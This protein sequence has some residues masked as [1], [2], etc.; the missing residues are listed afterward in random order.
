ML[1]YKVTNNINGKIYIGQTRKSIHSR[2]A[3]HKSRGH[4]LYAAI[5]KYGIENFTVKILCRCN[6]LEEMNHRETYYIKLFKSLAPKG[7][8][9]NSGG[10]KAFEVS[11]ET[12]RRLSE[13]H[14]GKKAPWNSYKRSA[15]TREKLSRIFTGRPGFW[16]GKKRPPEHFKTD[17]VLCLNNGVTYRSHRE[18]A[19]ALKVCFKKISLVVKGKRN[20]TGGYRFVRAVMARGKYA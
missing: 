2:W 14:K 11:D 16:T 7:Y 12:R 13:S 9:L 15:A 8:N 5:Q 4:V 6:S 1:V 3:A 17:P 10:G 19:K 18:A 20:H